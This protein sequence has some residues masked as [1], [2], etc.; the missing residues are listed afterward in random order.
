MDIITQSHFD[1][2]KKLY[3][4]EDQDEQKT[5]EL[6]CIYSIIS[7]FVKSE[8]LTKNLLEEVNIGNGNDW[9]IDGFII[10]VNGQIIINKQ[11]INDL[12]EA[13]GY[14]SSRIILIQ[15][16]TSVNFDIGEL[17][18][19]LDG[20][21][22]IF[23]EI[24]GEKHLPV[25]NSELTSFREIV[26]HLYSKSADFLEGINPS[27]H[28]YYITCGTYNSQ[29]DYSAKINS[30]EDY[31]KSTALLNTIKCEI[32]G[33][34]DIVDYYKQTKSRIEA[35]L[36]I[37]QK[38]AL[39]EVDK[40]EDSYL[41]LMPFCE[42]KKLYIDENDNIMNEVF[43]DNIR[44]FQG[45]NIVNKAMKESVRQGNIDL[46]AAM[47]NGIT[48]I[49]RKY[50]STGMNMTLID[51]QIVNGCQTCNVLYSCRKTPNIEN[52]KVTVKII[53]SADNDVKKNIIVA[54]NSQTEV[55][56]E[57]LVSL[58][59]VQK[60]IEDYYNAQNRFEKLYYERRSKQ[61]KNEETKVP[62]YK[63]VTIPMQILSFISM[64]MG[65]PE[66]VGGY[67]GRIVEE[68]DKNGRKV[69]S[70]DTNPALY[71][72]S[73]LASYKMAEAFSKNILEAK[74]KKIKFHLLLAFR[75]MSEPMS[76]PP[77]N[78]NKITSYCDHIC[79]ILCD[80]NMCK[81][82][83][84]AATKLI[85]QALG[86]EPTDNDRHNTDFTAKIK[87]IAAKANKINAKANK[88]NKNR[89]ASISQKASNN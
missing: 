31:L 11:V 67:Y 13:N 19:T 51:Y 71:Y 48:I 32:L 58:L 9:G 75:L 46:F 82:G 84:Y 61:Y 14:L 60:H 15:S 6:F 89:Q 44:A 64:M 4:Y 26:K 33:N 43:Y 85:D 52:L 47:N 36:K 21:E 73:A 2:F 65:K 27:L 57:Q 63:V 56:R 23:K 70:E 88:I 5:F 17:S 39:P 18:K 10:I 28:L 86:R 80:A 55:K 7:K 42:L 87:E 22:Y 79:T 16:K 59:E 30:T 74:Y 8:T 77:F 20:A 41:C 62:S 3:G 54:N 29:P 76:L 50:K 24:L 66:K 35:T 34:R 37:E 53:V 49:T 68:F 45:E 1:N 38:I 83:F 40:V 72:T 12:L 81:K 69:F 78:C 25:S